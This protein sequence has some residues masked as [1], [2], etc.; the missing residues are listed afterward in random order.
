MAVEIERKFLVDVHN[1]PQLVNGKVI[2][3]AYIKTQDNTVVRVRIKGDKGYL[4]IKGE[5]KG[6]V[7][8]EFE[9]EIP[10]NDAN[11]MINTL[12]AR[13]V[14]S[15]IRYELKI[16]AHI[17]EVDIF[18]EENKGLVIAEI[19]LPSEDEKISLPYWIKEEVTS[20]SRYYNSN[21]ISNPYINWDK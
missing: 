11:E 6:M 3:Q 1:L 13:P 12:C 7:R 14:I 2:K 15:K 10:L 17:W 5:N 19:E 4:T 16:D 20:D 9:Y 18:E 21:L 8:S